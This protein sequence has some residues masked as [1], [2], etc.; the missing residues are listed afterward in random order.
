MNK[1]ISS[2]LW[3]E[4]KRLNFRNQRELAERLGVSPSS[5]HNYEAGKRSPD[6]IYLAK[7]TEI[8]ADVLYILKGKRETNTL[9]D[10]EA[11]LVRLYRSV[12]PDKKQMVLAVS[13][14]VAEYKS[15]EKSKNVSLY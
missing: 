9:S 2:R 12:T 7:L 11:M 3:E 15:A 14:S 6:A 4:R 1:Q 8:G 10:D 13:E 5:V